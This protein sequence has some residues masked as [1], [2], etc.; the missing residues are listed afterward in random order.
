[1]FGDG[2][3]NK[4]FID[5][6]GDYFALAVSNRYF[7]YTKAGEYFKSA[8]AGFTVDEMKIPLII[9]EK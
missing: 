7:K 1:M 4:Y 2:I 9:I 5:L 8:H 3:E 6:L